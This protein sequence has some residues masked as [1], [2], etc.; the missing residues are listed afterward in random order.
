M[1]GESDEFREMN[2]R[3]FREKAGKFYASMLAGGREETA[4]EIADEAL[5]CD[6]SAAM[7]ITLVRWALRAEQPRPRQSGLL[8]EAAET[9]GA[10][11]IVHLRTE[12]V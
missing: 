12:L 3:M 10:E 1:R 11:S 8:D 4:D 5:E 2:E 6:D 7:R 9:D